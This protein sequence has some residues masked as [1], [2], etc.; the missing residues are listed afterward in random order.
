[1]LLNSNEL[2]HIHSTNHS[3]NDIS[4]RWGVIGAGQKGNKRLI[5]SQVTSF[6]MELLAIRH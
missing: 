3:V 6:R 1:M 2:E 5:Y 4:I